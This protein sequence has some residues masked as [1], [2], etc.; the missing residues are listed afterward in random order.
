MIRTSLC[1]QI[2]VGQL[3]GTPQ[4]LAA[5]STSNVIADVLWCLLIGAGSALDTLGSQ[6]WGAGN[7]AGLVRWAVMCSGQSHV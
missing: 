3:L 5:A 4:A 7:P 1:K 6:S 2:M